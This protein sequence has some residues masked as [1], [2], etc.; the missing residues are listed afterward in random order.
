MHEHVEF[1]ARAEFHGGIDEGRLARVRGDVGL[2]CYGLRC[3]V[4]LLDRLDHFFG[5]RLAFRRGVVDHH[6]GAA[7]T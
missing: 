5:A 1:A 4:G 3:G 6:V 2:D 7:S